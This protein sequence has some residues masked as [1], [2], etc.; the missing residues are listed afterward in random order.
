[1]LVLCA[2]GLC[3][4]VLCCPYGVARNAD[5]ADED[6]DYEAYGDEEDVGQQGLQPSKEDPGLFIVNCRSVGGGWEG[7]H[8]T[9]TMLYGSKNFLWV[10]CFQK[11]VP[12]SI[13]LYVVK[14]CRVCIL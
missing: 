8:E 1:M 4:A 2:E 13:A 11:K 9:E 12:S 10:T 6:D 14:P 3:C 5:V 7:R